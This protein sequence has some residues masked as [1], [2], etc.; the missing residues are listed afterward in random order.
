MMMTTDERLER[1]VAAK[2]S[3]QLVCADL[4]AINGAAGPLE[5]LIV[6][7]QIAHANKLL[8]FLKQYREAMEAEAHRP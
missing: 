1:A 5:H 6:V 2:E 8:L 3:M 4:L 7:E